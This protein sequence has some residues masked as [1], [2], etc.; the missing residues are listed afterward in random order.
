MYQLFR[1]A[2]PL[3]LQREETYFRLTRWLFNII[4]LPSWSSLIVTVPFQI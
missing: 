2:N 4:S 1:K 3:K